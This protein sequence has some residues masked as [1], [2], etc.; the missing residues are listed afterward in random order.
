MRQFYTAAAT[1]T[2]LWRRVQMELSIGRWTYLSFPPCA[3]MT[4][5]VQCL[6]P[7]ESSRFNC[8]CG[9]FF[10]SHVAAGTTLYSFL[11]VW[12]GGG[13]P[14]R[15]AEMFTRRVAVGPIPS[16]GQVD[17]GSS[18]TAGPSVVSNQSCFSTEGMFCSGCT[19]SFL[20][21]KWWVDGAG[22]VGRNFW[23]RRR[24]GAHFS[25][26]LRWNW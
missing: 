4:H 21:M 25:T 14:W 5:P 13:I 10:S 24:S 6:F 12:A 8:G 19:I 16:A 22:G 23:W 7:P 15:Q 11:W 20:P 18:S 2:V 17:E 1:S 26:F 9:A 3:P